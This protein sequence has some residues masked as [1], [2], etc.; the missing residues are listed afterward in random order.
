MLLNAIAT[1][2]GAPT[3]G[4]SATTAILGVSAE[5]SHHNNAQKSPNNSSSGANDDLRIGSSTTSSMDPK[6]PPPD[7]SEVP[8]MPKKRH[9]PSSLDLR[10][11]DP[12]NSDL[13][14]RIVSPGLP[15]LSAEMKSTVKMSQ[16]IEQQQKSL[17]AAR[18]HL[19]LAS[20]VSLGVQAPLADLPP[21][22]MPS[23]HIIIVNNGHNSSVSSA[24]SPGDEVDKLLN[25]G[26][27]SRG[28]K[29]SNVPTPLAISHPNTPSAA[30]FMP[31]IQSA[32]I[33]P[34]RQPAPRP[35]RRY[36]HPQKAPYQIQVL[37][38]VQYHPYGAPPR[39]LMR[40][41]PGAP[42]HLPYM[43]Q[44]A[45]TTPYPPPR[46]VRM[47]PYGPNYPRSRPGAGAPPPPGATTKTPKAKNLSVTDV[48][49]G[50]FTKA[51]PLQSQ[52]LSAQKEHFE[53]GRDDD[54]MPVS[55]D[56]I[57]EM[58]EKYRDSGAAEPEAAAIDEYDERQNG[59][60]GK[61]DIFGSL[62]L[63]NESVF[64]FRIFS[65]VEDDREDDRR[66]RDKDRFL[67]ICE[68]SWDEF[69]AGRT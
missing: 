67:K 41:A 17:I 5:P 6:Q 14:L 37:P 20:S 13:A 39:R 12:S 15:Q 55:D 8:E 62:N 31:S 27:A 23:E 26:S 40:P 66:L 52:P 45:P 50:D 2:D 24:D 64:N 58:Q 32:P 35:P 19:S 47:V 7:A 59:S 43:Y 1:V 60:T 51:A 34:Y 65:A 61:S 29:R 38:Y 69:V 11:T 4:P 53:R 30:T 36:L 28:L 16:K 46:R 54:R 9:R 21:P 22:T 44:V 68:T 56:E 25:Q 3:S 48:Y 63:M 57:R 10:S 33:R 18:Q 49:H 42:I